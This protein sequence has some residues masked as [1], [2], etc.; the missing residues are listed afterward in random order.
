MTLLR[1]IKIR[2]KK[3]IT[4]LIINLI[5][6]IKEGIIPKDMNMEYVILNLKKRYKNSVQTIEEYV[7]LY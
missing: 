2:R 7:R 4:K 5:N 1:P 6:I 3:K